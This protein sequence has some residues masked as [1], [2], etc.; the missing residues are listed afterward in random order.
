MLPPG[1]RQSQNGH[2][3]QKKRDGSTLQG[4]GFKGPYVF[5]NPPNTFVRRSLDPV[6]AEPQEVFGGPS[7]Y[8]EGIWKPIGGS[9]FVERLKTTRWAPGT[10][11][12]TW[13]FFNS[14]YRREISPHWGPHLFSAIYRGPITL[15]ITGWGPTMTI[16]DIQ[17]MHTEKLGDCKLTTTHVPL[18]TNQSI[19]TFQVNNFRKAV[20]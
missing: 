2:M 10:Y 7:T 20:G 6:K 5:Q 8:W 15:V 17:V 18:L 12:Y 14:T 1:R 19:I 13:S 16:A 4:V 11:I 3:S 9:I